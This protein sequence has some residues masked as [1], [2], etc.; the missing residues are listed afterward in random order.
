MSF[1]YVIGNLI[2]C[3]HNYNISQNSTLPIILEN[4]DRNGDRKQIDRTRQG[5]RCNCACIYQKSGDM[6]LGVPFNIASYACLKPSDFIHTLG[7]AHI[8]LNHIEPLKIQLILQR[9][10]TID[11]FKAEDFQIEGYNSHPTIKM[12]MAV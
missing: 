8:Y 10:E 2:L 6:G 11:D 1:D 9:V 12:E 5:Q 4:V 3:I 7:D